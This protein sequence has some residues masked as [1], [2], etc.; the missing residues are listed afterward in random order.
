MNSQ[1]FAGWLSTLSP[2]ERITAV[3]LTYSNLTVCARE[4]FLPEYNRGALDSVVKKVQGLNE[5]HHKLASQLIDLSTGA[6][7]S[8][9]QDVF[10]DILFDTAERHSVSE[11][12]NS[13][14]QFA[15]TRKWPV[16]S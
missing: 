16:R 4:L 14:I 12:L 6:G 3:A 13:A 11:Y 7:E 2:A 5:L 8:H 15:Q 10:S 1:I 9:P